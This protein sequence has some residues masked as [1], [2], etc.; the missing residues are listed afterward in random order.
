MSGLQD[1]APLLVR[2]VRNGFVESVHGG[3]VAICDPDGTVLGAL[4]NP[5]LE[6]YPRSSLKPFQAVA[7]LELLAEA[8]VSLSVE[9]RAISTASHDAADEH[10][11]EAAHLLALANLEEEALQCPPALPTDEAARAAAAGAT[12]RLAHNC[13]GKHAGFLYAQAAAGGDP[14]DYLAPDSIIQRRVAAAVERCCRTTI[15]GQGVDGCGAPAL[16]LPL[17]ALATGFARLIAGQDGLAPVRDAMS[18]RPDLVGGITAVDTQ[19]MQADSRVV[20]KR[21]AE[22]VLAAG[23]A[24]AGGPVG[25]AVKIA[26]AGERATGPVVAA[27]LERCG[28]TVPASI[29][30]PAVLG[31][32][33]PQGALEVEAA[34]LAAL[35]DGAA[36]A[37]GSGGSGGAGGSGGSG[38]AGGS[39][40]SGGSGGPG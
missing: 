33:A 39:G 2:V 37:G 20:A 5:D 32:G 19:L 10:Q 36:P 26:D 31:G 35:A 9:G 17:A 3:H 25:I 8:G 16:R 30:R 12:Q 11:I 38:G 6:I 14:G 15:T 4:G 29:R 28:A 1:G 23:F 7:T 18:A 27:L 34:V 24:G 13:S 21:G 22:A 40:G